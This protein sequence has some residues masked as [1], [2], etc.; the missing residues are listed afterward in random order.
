MKTSHKLLA[1]AIS[2][3]A[4]HATEVLAEKSAA[5]EEIVV[6]ARKQSE[7]IQDVP[8]AV[9]A[10]SAD[11]LAVAGVR[12]VADLSTLVP[13]L[14]VTANSNPFTT[15]FKIRR[16][17]NEGNIPDFEPDTGLFIDGA[18]RSR[19]GLGLGDLVDIDRIEVLRGPQSTLYGKNVTAGVV[20]VTTAEP[21][22]TFGAMGEVTAGN[23]GYQQFRGY[24][25]GGLTDTLSGRISLSGTK[26]DAI[27][28][29]TVG[30]DGN[31]LDQ[32]A[33]RGQ[34]LFQPNDALRG[35]LIVAHSY[36]DMKPLMGD[37]HYGPTVKAVVNG[38]VNGAATNPAGLAPADGVINAG[39]RP[40]TDNDPSDRSVQFT[41][42]LT[43]AQKADDFIASVEYQN[44][45]FTLTSISSYDN[46]QVIQNWNDAGQTGLDLVSY[47]DTQR[48]Y[49][50]SQEFRIDALLTTTLNA[51]AGV[52]YYDNNF[53]RGDP[54]RDEF[55]TGSAIDELGVVGSPQHLPVFGL[56]GDTGNYYEAADSESTGVFTQ[57][58]W[59]ATDDLTLTL[60]LRYTHESKDVTLTD[61]SHTT[62][63]PGLVA[64][65]T[66]VGKPPLVNT[67]TPA[68]ASFSADNSWNAVTGSFNAEYHLDPDSMLY[69]TVATG[70]KGG[71]YNGGFGNTPFAKRA[72]GD[73]RVIH[74]ELGA[75]TEVAKRVRLNAAA[76][77]TE[78]D[79][80]Q[81]A[82]FVGLQ[83]LVNNAEKVIVK[84]VETDVIAKVT[85]DITIDAA[86]S[87]AD[88]YYDKYTQGSCY[89][90]RP[91]NTAPAR[92][93][94]LSDKTL[95]FAPTLT[96]NAGVQWE[97]GFG[98]GTLYSRLDTNWTGSQNVTTELD[99]NHGEKGGYALMN[100][101]L[102]WKQDQWDVSGWVRNL[103]DKTYVTQNAQSN[104][105]AGLQ[106]GSYQSYLGAPRS[107]GV[108]ARAKF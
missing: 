29:N 87:Y 67:L 17:G 102:G 3:L 18:F 91:E 19:S 42:A 81:A 98:P 38:V 84:G 47:R 9:S 51:Q 106:D 90:G 95:P 54:S 62:L 68:S 60:G 100:F 30:D 86:A 24:V 105:F 82:S 36:R 15:S 65:L 104:I 69:G 27:Q 78:Y 55:V 77:L 26:Q 23:N 10:L 33:W 45:S 11:Q 89:S 73:E 5:L 22:Q 43:F 108:T 85:D 56:P 53:R 49:T 103:G 48:G 71:G 97:H 20:S 63:S 40:I 37:M 13:S 14:A 8:I 83:F 16:I 70:F 7:L 39:A 75:K 12:D 4:V 101:R 31:D 92:P 76:F 94:D 88:A 35:R 50:F 58:A 66:S 28:D 79:D 59:S 80:Y 57:G 72:F 21:S 74:Y 6:S 44:D 46:Y 107:F 99:P 96:A 1:L 2:S 41:E 34:L 64:L 61:T 93:C 52:F 25:N 32:Y